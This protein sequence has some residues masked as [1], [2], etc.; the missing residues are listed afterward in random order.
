MPERVCLSVFCIVLHFSLEAVR[1]FMIFSG[2]HGREDELLEETVSHPSTMRRT[3]GDSSLYGDGLTL[4]DGFRQFDI[5]AKLGWRKCVSIFSFGDSTSS[6][7]G[8]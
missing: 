4:G 7:S 2:S 5:G 8:V 6:R 1:L 3:T